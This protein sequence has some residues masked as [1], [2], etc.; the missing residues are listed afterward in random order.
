MHKRYIQALTAI[1]LL[2]VL[3]I[4]V[5][6][7]KS[8]AF[9]KNY[10]AACTYFGH[11]PDKIKMLQKQGVTLEELRKGS[12]QGSNKI[13]INQVLYPEVLGFDLQV[14]AEPDLYGNEAGQTIPYSLLVC[15]PTVSKNSAPDYPVPDKNI[16][17]PKMHTPG[18]PVY[19]SSEQKFPLILISH[20]LG[21]DPLDDRIFDLAAEG[22]IVAA[23]FHGDLRFPFPSLLNL[24]QIQLL[25]L[26][27][28]TLT[29]TIDYLLEH[30]D[31]KNSIDPVRIGGVGISLGGTTMLALMGAEI[32]GPDMLDMRNTATDKRLTA[33]ANIVPFM[34]QKYL[35]PVFGLHNQG[36]QDIHLPYL[37]YSSS[38][39]HVSDIDMVKSILKTKPGSHYLVQI[40]G[41]DHWLS[42]EAVDNG[43]KWVLAFLDAHLKGDPQAGEIL[44]LDNSINSSV[45]N[46]MVSAVPISQ[47]YSEELFDLVEIHFPD[48]FQSSSQ[49]QT[50]NGIVYRHYFNEN[51]F[52]ASYA[53]ELYI[54]DSM[55]AHDLGPVMYWWTELSR[56][57]ADT[58]P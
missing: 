5:V 30:S 23:P 27:P 46:S 11:N 51:L 12:T 38:A 29:A 40:E 37:A 7:N 15:Y 32:I 16:S 2:L 41:E 3:I 47:K 50:L 18:S 19:I 33:A 54:V 35:F 25:S 21:M 14:P 13:Y 1:A 39:D 49:S 55:G 28:L 52:L 57:N 26:R 34:G 24:R 44:V 4:G 22:Y 45:E 8:F 36:C 9:E 10:P 56:L 53:N 17:I 58:V 20:G 31:F 6:Q 43:F 42:D 48:L